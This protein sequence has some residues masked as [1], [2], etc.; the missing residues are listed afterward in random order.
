MC[1]VHQWKSSRGAGDWFKEVAP[2]YGKSESE[3]ESSADGR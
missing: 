1:A 3:R 2:R